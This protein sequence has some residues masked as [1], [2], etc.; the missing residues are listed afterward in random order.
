MLEEASRR[1]RNRSASWSAQKTIRARRR[2]DGDEDDDD[3]EDTAPLRNYNTRLLLLSSVLQRFGGPAI[4]E[5]NIPRAQSTAAKK[6]S[7]SPRPKYE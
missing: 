1:P 2:S 3:D 6:F 7:G 5:N 4:L